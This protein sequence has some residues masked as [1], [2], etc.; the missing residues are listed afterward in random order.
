MEHVYH[1]FPVKNELCRYAKYNLNNSSQDDIEWYSWCMVNKNN[2]VTIKKNKMLFNSLTGQEFY[3]VKDIT[4]NIHPELITK[5][6]KLPKF[7]ENTAFKYKGENSL[8]HPAFYLIS[9]SAIEEKYPPR[10]S[11]KSKSL[12]SH[13]LGGCSGNDAFY[14]LSRNYPSDVLNV[15]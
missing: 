6:S 4:F 1:I 11:D 3:T 8:I 13:I 12:I 10:Y 14:M 9:E 7:T 2:K 15:L 5:Q